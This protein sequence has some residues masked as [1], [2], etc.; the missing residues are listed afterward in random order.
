MTRGGAAAPR[1]RLV[2]GSG[3][4]LPLLLLAAC[5]GE[6]APADA[7]AMLAQVLESHRASL[8]ASLGASVPTAAIPGGTARDGR[9]DAPAPLRSA[10]VGRAG[11][12]P[13]E[14]AALLDQLPEALIRALGPPTLRRREGDAE[15]W[16]YDAGTCQLDLIFYPKGGSLRV[17]WAAARAA[18]TAR[19]TEAA[20]LD[21]F[22]PRS[23]PGGAGA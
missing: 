17:G 3:P 13:H 18:G 14:A 22:K 12:A 2:G 8:G 10:G 23:G 15:I 9:G 1:S 19:V 7:G 20:C 6:T 11:S 16:L 21:T 5:A 4:L